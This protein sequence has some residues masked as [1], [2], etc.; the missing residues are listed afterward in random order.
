MCGTLGK[1]NFGV[2]EQMTE[3]NGRV[4]DR[5]CNGWYQGTVR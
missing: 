3:N 2:A 1:R 4:R 5:W